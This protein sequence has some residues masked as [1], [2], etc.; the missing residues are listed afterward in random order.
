MFESGIKYYTNARFTVHFPED[1]VCCA[2]CPLMET[3]SRKQCRGTGEYIVD[4]RT[5]GYIC[6]LQFEEPKK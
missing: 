3:Y 2:F 1:K 5:I 4:D 6:P